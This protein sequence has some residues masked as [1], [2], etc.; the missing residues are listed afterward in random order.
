MRFLAVL[1]FAVLASANLGAGHIKHSL[2]SRTVEEL[3]DKRETNSGR[4]RRGLPPLPPT[5][6]ALGAIRPRTSAVACSFQSLPDSG[7]GYIQIAFQANGSVIGYISNTLYS[8][9]AYTLTGSQNSAA[10]FQ[11][12]S[13][14]SP[15]NGPYP[16]VDLLEVEQEGGHIF[17]GAVGSTDGNQ[18]GPGE[19]GFAYLGRTDQVAANSPAVTGSSSVSQDQSYAS[20]AESTIWS[21]DCNTLAITAQWTNADDS[22]PTTTIFY[23]LWAGFLGLTS[24]IDA[25]NNAKGYT[26][27]TPFA[28]TF[29]FISMATNL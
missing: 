24:D 26:F 16:I 13:T 21:L 8:Q 15:F 23:D 18:L 22:Q 1:L 29:T 12:F 19:A 2:P 14:T 7:I 3:L 9:G 10:Q 5:R 6:R 25:Y 17:L 20:V 4:L 27:I 11:W 28:V